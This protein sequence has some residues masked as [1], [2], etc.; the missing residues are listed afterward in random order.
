MPNRPENPLAATPAP[1]PNPP[2]ALHKPTV[3]ILEDEITTA[4][5]LKRV[6]EEAGATVTGVVSSAR[7]FGLWEAQRKLAPEIICADINLPWT[8]GLRLALDL[9]SKWKLARIICMTAEN[10]ARVLQEV[11]NANIDGFISKRSRGST[12]LEHTIRGVL[13]GRRMMENFDLLY[14]QTL[15]EDP[16]LAKLALTETEAAVLS[17]I[18]AGATLKEIGRLMA[19]TELNVLKQRKRLMKKL[20]I[21]DNT[22]LTTVATRD[23]FTMQSHRTAITKLRAADSKPNRYLRPDTES[24]GGPNGPPH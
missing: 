8:H 13:E 12:S 24:C 9:R 3:L 16:S 5:H 18:G 2:R 15:K 6:F 11:N 4:D 20:L 10:S 21:S 23:G 17:Y 14:K 7:E 19:R 1:T 22:L